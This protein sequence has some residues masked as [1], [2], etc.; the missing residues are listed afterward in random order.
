[1]LTAELLIT[2]IRKK[3]IQPKVQQQKN[4]RKTVHI[5]YI[6]ANRTRFRNINTASYQNGVKMQAVYRMMHKV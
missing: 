3:K 2:G 1:M 5:S 6:I 4:K